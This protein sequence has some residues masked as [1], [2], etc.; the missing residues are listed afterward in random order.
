MLSK[1]GW[2]FLKLLCNKH[3]TG[4]KE[5]LRSLV[6]EESFEMLSNIAYSSDNPNILLFQPEALIASTHYS[7][8][9]PMLQDIPESIRPLLIRS[10]PTDIAKKLINDEIAEKENERK[11]S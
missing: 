5:A 9:K 8:F 7:W 10:L 3:F 4:S 1:S 6:D 11:V 2:N